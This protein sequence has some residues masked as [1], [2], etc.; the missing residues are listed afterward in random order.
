[1]SEK[2]KDMKM[3]F[4]YNLEALR[5][6]AAVIVVFCH[7][8]YYSDVL[9]PNYKCQLI[10]NYIPPAHFS[11]L[12]FF[13]LSGFLIGISNPNPL[14]TRHDIFLYLKKRFVRLYPI[15]LISLLITLPFVYK[16]GFIIFSKHLI[17][18]QGLL[19]GV[20]FENNPLWSLNY[21]VLYY[22][23][24]IFISF[25]E[26]KPR[27]IILV[28]ILI[29]LFWVVIYNLYP[30]RYLSI[31]S[32]YL[33]GFFFWIFGYLLSKV[34]FKKN[35][36]KLSYRMLISLMF[37][38]LS[39]SYKTISLPENIGNFF[40]QS[41]GGII[42]QDLLFLPFSVYCI[43]IFTNTNFRFNKLIKI[44]IYFSPILIFFPFIY[45]L[46]LPESYYLKFSFYLIS[47]LFL[48]DIKFVEIVSFKIINS[49]IY[50]GSIS[51]AIY[52]IHFPL[53]S[54]F[55]KIKLYS[56]N[57]LNFSIRLT[58]YLIIL[59]LLSIL[60]EKYFQ[61]WIRKKIKL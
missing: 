55:N 8:F 12:L 36:T 16:L 47:L 38:I 41:P 2:Y 29:F 60:F 61:P 14:K 28:L 3:K 13:V 52:V 17:F 21:E 23:V 39:T 43:L 25:F 5:G 37:F 7:I 10:G 15:Y 6:I 44:I 46:Y 57:I 18:G 45:N 20:Y 19:C 49:C 32:G 53:L 51:Y 11:V 58:L 56:G 48:I 40:D 26:F 1:M 42:I 24:F 27:T 4:E 59:I 31:L 30:H 9:D 35:E 54:Y 34:V 50:L 33:L 22:I